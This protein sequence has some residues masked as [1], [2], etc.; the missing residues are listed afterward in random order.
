M[1]LLRF[2]RNSWGNFLCD[3]IQHCIHHNLNSIHTNFYFTFNKCVFII[4]SQFKMELNFPNCNSG[5]YFWYDVSNGRYKT[6]PG[7]SQWNFNYASSS[8]KYELME[9]I[10]H[11]RIWSD[12]IGG[13][14]SRISRFKTT[15]RVELNN[16]WENNSLKKIGFCH[17]LKSDCLKISLL[18]D[19]KDEGSE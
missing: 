2:Y 3:P 18:S 16:W 10:Y 14:K 5:R 7:Q 8:R 6:K 19:Q 11:H 17:Q 15:V 12:G 1:F 4:R 9:L 13:T